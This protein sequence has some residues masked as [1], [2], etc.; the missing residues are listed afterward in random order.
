MNTLSF[1][2][3][4]SP[5]AVLGDTIDGMSKK[6]LVVGNWKMNPQMSLEAEHIFNE[7]K[8]IAVRLKK[9]H[10]VVC[11]PYVFLGDL[12]AIYSGKKI[13][14]GAQDVFWEKRGPYTGEISIDQLKDSSVRYV[15]IGHSERRRLGDTNDIV[16]RKMETVIS[17]NLIPILCVGESKRDDHGDYLA[18]ISEELR[19][20]FVN[21]PEKKMK[22]VVIAY[23]PIWAIGQTKEDAMSPH[24]MHQMTLFIRK[25]LMSMFQKSLVSGIKILYGGSVEKGNSEELIKEGNIDGFL[26]GRASLDAKHFSDILNIVEK[27]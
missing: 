4:F 22:N 16:K 23:E 24:D 2:E 17:T 3:C 18:F 1:V 10:A 26:V 12:Q 13:S 9:V 19:S 27:V 15:L 21:I 8:K 25:I 14:I 5:K 20:A 11:S 6:R 7:I